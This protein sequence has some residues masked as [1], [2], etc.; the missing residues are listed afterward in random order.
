MTSVGI[1]V[2]GLKW[3]TSFV[4]FCTT[5]FDKFYCVKPWCTV[6]FVVNSLLW[7]CLLVTSSQ[8]GSKC[9][10]FFIWFI[11]NSSRCLF[12]RTIDQKKW[13]KFFFFNNLQNSIQSRNESNSNYYVSTKRGKKNTTYRKF[14]IINVELLKAKKQYK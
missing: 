2:F 8:G 12:R 4:K 9:F 10:A 5:F 1:G 11:C 6:S 13:N 14:F 3:S 7:C